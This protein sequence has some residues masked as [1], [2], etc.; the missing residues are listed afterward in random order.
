M[1]P[2]TLI[3]IT[4]FENNNNNRVNIYGH[5]EDRKFNPIRLGAIRYA[6]TDTINLPLRKDDTDIGHFVYIR[7]LEI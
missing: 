6:K 3:D 7:N 5:S 4:T 1:F 2:V